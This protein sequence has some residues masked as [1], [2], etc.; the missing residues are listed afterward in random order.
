MSAS[1]PRT[2]TATPTEGSGPRRW[3][4]RAHE[5]WERVTE[6][7]ALQELWASGQ[8]IFLVRGD[9]AFRRPAAWAS[10]TMREV[11]GAVDMF[12][13]NARQHDDITC[14]VLRRTEP[15]TSLG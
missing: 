12:V 11:M 3:F 9:E 13:G 4:R 6:G 7:L 8:G 15:V 5:F 2:A 14:L 10:D 1:V